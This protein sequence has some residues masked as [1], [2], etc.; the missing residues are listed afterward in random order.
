MA[1][2][3]IAGELVRALGRLDPVEADDPALGLRDDL[4]RDDED[5]GV[6]E[7]ARPVGRLRQERH[8]IV[9]LLD[10]RDALEREDPDPGGH[11]RPVM[12]TPACAL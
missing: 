4:L 3:A 6:L 8:E 1:R 10:L 2:I 5:V 9:A 11:G 7:P 12:R